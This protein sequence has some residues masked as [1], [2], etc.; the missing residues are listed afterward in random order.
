MSEEERAAL[1]EAY[2]KI[3]E[4]LEL[5]LEPSMKTVLGIREVC[6]A[7]VAARNSVNRLISGERIPF[8]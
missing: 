3:S 4:A 1:N 2:Q 5:L 8:R 6:E 7:V